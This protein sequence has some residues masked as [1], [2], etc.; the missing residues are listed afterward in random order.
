MLENE[1][2]KQIQTQ[3]YA[4]NFFHSNRLMI[5]KSQS[6]KVVKMFFYFKR[7]KEL[8]ISTDIE[9]IDF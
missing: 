4:E 5:R 3:K 7:F 8:K 9:R 2:K 1:D 6:N